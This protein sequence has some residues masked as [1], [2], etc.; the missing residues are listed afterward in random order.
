MV[1]HMK[2][3]LDMLYFQYSIQHN[4]LY[5][6]AITPDNYTFRIE[7]AGLHNEING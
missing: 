4:S 7:R 2:E 6:L 1:V 3:K 5:S